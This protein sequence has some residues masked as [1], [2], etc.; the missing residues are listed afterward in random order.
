MGVFVPVPVGWEEWRKLC[1][2]N[3]QFMSTNK[4]KMK[5]DMIRLFCHERFIVVTNIPNRILVLRF[6]IF[7]LATLKTLEK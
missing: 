1:Y 6:R 3:L 7:V 4:V 5:S 2:P